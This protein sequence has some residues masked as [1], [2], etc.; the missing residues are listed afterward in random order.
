[1]ELTPRCPQ[2]DVLRETENDVA[3]F[4][5][6]SYEVKVFAVFDLDL[7]C[8]TIKAHH[9]SNHGAVLGWPQDAF[10]PYAYAFAHLYSTVTLVV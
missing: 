8:Y 5:I 6:R 3:S 2:R 10:D 4:H 1:M 9:M 7:I